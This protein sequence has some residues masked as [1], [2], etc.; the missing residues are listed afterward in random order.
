MKTLSVVIPFFQRKPGILGKTLQS[1]EDQ[2]IPQGWQ[3]RAVLIDD[4]SPLPARQEVLGYELTGPRTLHLVEQVNSGV[5][6]ARNHGLKI[7]VPKSD[8]IAFLDSDNIWPSDH[9]ARAIAA[10]DEGFDFYFTDNRRA[11]CHEAHVRSPHVLCTAK[12]ISEANKNSGIIELSIDKIVNL[13]F[14]EFPCQASTVVYRKKIAPLL[15]F[16]TQLKSSGEDVLF[17]TEL[18]ARSSRVG[19]DLDSMVE[20]GKDVNIFFSNLGWDALRFLNINVD[21]LLTRRELAK[22]GFLGQNNKALNEGRIKTFAGELSF[23]LVQNLLENPGKATPQ[24][25]RLLK[26][27]PGAGIRVFAGFPQAIVGKPLGK[28]APAKAD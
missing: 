16:S 27:D 25:W 12:L 15:R 19:F 22:A 13:C 7:A 14:W 5:G 23:H 10:L 6:A 18:L 26:T 3:L 11:G 20:C 4:G 1:I 9:V 28:S 8:A 24:A 21:Q 2:T 17:F